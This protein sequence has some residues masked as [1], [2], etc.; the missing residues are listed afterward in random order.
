MGPDTDLDVAFVINVLMVLVKYILNI[1]H[2]LALEVPRPAQWI[3]WNTTTNVLFCFFIPNLL[4]SIV[5]NGYYRRKAFISFPK[6]MR[7]YS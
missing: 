3:G 5:I 2:S 4:I 7:N 1:Y 6:E